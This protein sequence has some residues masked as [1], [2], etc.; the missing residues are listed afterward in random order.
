[1]LR[2]QHQ[3][4]EKQWV[5]LSTFLGAI[6]A[7]SHLIGRDSWSDIPD[8]ERLLIDRDTKDETDD[9]GNRHRDGANADVAHHRR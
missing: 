7:L 4:L 6:L 8:S 1:M 3:S 9:V 2:S 5:K